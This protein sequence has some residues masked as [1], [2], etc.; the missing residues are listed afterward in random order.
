MDL[1]KDYKED[2][3]LLV[4]LISSS[5]GTILKE[6]DL[7]LILEIFKNVSNDILLN[8]RYKSKNITVTDEHPRVK[9]IRKKYAKDKNKKKLISEEVIFNYILK[10]LIK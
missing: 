2:D 9:E 5:I 3:I 7:Q 1:L 4:K 6:E 10:I 8:V